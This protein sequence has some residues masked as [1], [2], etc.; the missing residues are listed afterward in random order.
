MLGSHLLYHSSSNRG[1]DWQ[2]ASLRSCDVAV[3]TLLRLITT[4]FGETWN[5]SFD[6]SKLFIVGHSNGGQGAWYRMSHYSTL[7]G[8]VAAGYIKAS[9]LRFGAFTP[10]TLIIRLFKYFHTPDLRLRPIR[11][12]DR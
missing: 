6:K 8:V 3:D 7:G 11:L 5:W 9:I 2:L 1:Y 10:L 12:A 4:S